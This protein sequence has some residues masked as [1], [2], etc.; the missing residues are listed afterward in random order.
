MYVRS[1]ETL[2]FQSTSP[3]WRT[4][5]KSVQARYRKAFQSTSPVW[6]TTTNALDA[7]VDMLISI[8]VPRVEDDSYF[9][10]LLSFQSDFNPRPPCGGRQKNCTIPSW[11]NFIS[12]HVPRVEDDFA[13][14]KTCFTSALFQ[15]TSPVWRTTSRPR[16]AGRKHRNFNPRPP[17]GGRPCRG[18]ADRQRGSISIHV[19]RVEDDSKTIG[20]PPRAS[21]FQSTSP[22]WRTTADFPAVV[23]LQPVRISIHVPRVEDDP[24]EAIRTFPFRC[25]SIHVPRVEDD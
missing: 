14:M 18:S 19:P 4:T 21:S 22:V 8:H 6:R 3:V 17:C 24:A 23:K 1:C 5:S 15:S 20:F 16:A 12:I 10:P 13:P 11:L 7:R 2:L 25:I 9:A